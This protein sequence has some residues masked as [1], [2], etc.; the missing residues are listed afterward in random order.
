M[1]ARLFGKLAA[2]AVA[3]GAAALPA[4]AAFIAIDDSD[5]LTITITAGDFEGG[6][7]VNGT[8]LTSGIGNSASVTLV[9]ADGGY[10]ISGSWIDLGLA[11]GKRV[12]ILFAIDSN[13]TFTTSGLEFGVTS[14]GSNGT[15]NGTFGGY[16]NPSL[17]FS[18]GLPTVSQDGHTELGGVDFLS[19]SFKSEL[20]PAPGSLALSGLALLALP[21]LRR[22]RAD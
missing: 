2:A 14:D 11:A 5:P 6:F 21:L 22:R 10:S 3:I 20:I 7:S 12:D 18:T 4:H 16:I 8:L 17:Y 9:D 1:K 13:P 15:L 19:V